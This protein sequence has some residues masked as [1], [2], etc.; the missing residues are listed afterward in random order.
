MENEVVYRGCVESGQLIS[1][2]LNKLGINHR[3]VS[4]K[5][6]SLPEKKELQHC[7]IETDDF[8]IETNPSQILGIGVG[9]LTLTKDTWRE[10]TEPK[11]GESLFS[12]PSLTEAGKRFYDAEAEQVLR[13]FRGKQ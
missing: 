4:G 2:T 10:L 7:W 5:V 9:A 3:R 6:K 12:G 8:I 1:I 13:C 11:E